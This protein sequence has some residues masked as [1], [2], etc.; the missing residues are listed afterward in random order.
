M[1]TQSLRHQR[2]GPGGS[3]MVTLFRKSQGEIQRVR[4]LIPARFVRLMGREAFEN[5]DD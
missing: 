3:E 1:H 5:E 4:D 2:I